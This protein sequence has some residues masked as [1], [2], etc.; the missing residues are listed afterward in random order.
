MRIRRV[1]LVVALALTA[2]GSTPAAGPPTI[3]TPAGVSVSVLQYRSD[4]AIRHIEIKVTNAGESPIVVTRA[5]LSSTAFLADTVWNSRDSADET[6]IKPGTST[7]LPALLTPSACPGAAPFRSTARLDLRG[8]DGTLGRTAA[9]AVADPFASIVQVHTEDCRRAAALNIADLALVE[10]LR[11]ER[12]AGALV[13]LLDLRLTPTGRSGTLTLESVGPTTLLSPPTGDAWT[14][15]RSVSA[16][17]GS[18]TVTLELRASR[19][20]PHAIAEDKLGTV[21]PL[22]LTLD[23]GESGIV[24]VPADRQLRQQIQTF[25]HHACAVG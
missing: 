3:A 9:L 7:D 23:G 13:G 1:G 6:T 4:Y 24:T 5:G 12:R 15:G 16:E 18:Q 8:P 19:C 10:P 14:I 21:L 22:K 17:S 2:C 20:D 11:T 25:V